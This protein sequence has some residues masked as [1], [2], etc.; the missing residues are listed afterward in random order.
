MTREELI[1]ELTKLTSGDD[2]YEDHENAD[3][4]LLT[5]INDPKVTTLFNTI[6]KWYA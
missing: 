4:L 2:P 5:F 6:E 3:N 1:K